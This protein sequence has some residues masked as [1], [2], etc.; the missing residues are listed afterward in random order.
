MSSRIV[1][2]G[3][4][5]FLSLGLIAVLGYPIYE[6]YTTPR[7]VSALYVDVS[8]SNQKA[9]FKESLKKACE[10]RLNSLMEDDI[11]INNK[12]AEIPDIPKTY[13]Y[14]KKRDEVGILKACDQI[15]ERPNALGHQKGTDLSKAIKDMRSQVSQSQDRVAVMMVFVNAN[16]AVKTAN[17]PGQSESKEKSNNSSSNSKQDESHKAIKEL[18]SLPGQV[19]IFV[20]D[21]NLFNNIAKS[22]FPKNVQIASYETAADL[23]PKIHQKVRQQA[24]QK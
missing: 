15:Q 19:V 6:D 18:S 12:F 22:S 13:Q 9:N 4:P 8:E 7:I 14:V 24:N 10:A 2:Q 1:Q 3:L 23:I 5:I 20:S 21:V 17:N 16:E 11:L